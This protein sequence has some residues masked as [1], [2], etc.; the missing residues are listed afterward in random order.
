MSSMGQQVAAVVPAYNEAQTISHVLE[1]L[2]QC[3]EIDEIIVVNDGS[4]DDTAEKAAELGI[5]VVNLYPN[6]GKGGAMRAGV[7]ASSAD[8]ILFIDADLIGLTHAHCHA[9]LEPVLQ[10]VADMT[11]GL[12][13]GGRPATTLAQKVA[14]FLSGQRALRREIIEDMPELD[15][16]GYGVDIAISRYAAS[17]SIRVEKV[18]LQDVS[19]IMKEEKQ[20]FVTGAKNVM[21][22]WEILKVLRTK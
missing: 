21:M 16:S 3:P 2:Q 9:L 14:P 4:T 7:K 13:E 5:R 12:F 19:Q 10:D 22:Y 6:R 20:G 1:V 17:K 8:I 11:V 18:P 15:D